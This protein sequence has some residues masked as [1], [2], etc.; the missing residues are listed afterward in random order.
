MF[1]RGYSGRLGC[2]NYYFD[3]L[4]EIINPFPNDLRETMG[5]CYHQKYK[6]YKQ[7]RINRNGLNALCYL[8]QVI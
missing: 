3:L 2:I 6:Q 5:S 7:S 4:S 8:V 1:S